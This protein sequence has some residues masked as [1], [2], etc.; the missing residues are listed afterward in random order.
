MSEL[1]CMMGKEQWM[2]E[3]VCVPNKQPNPAI[4]GKLSR[5]VMSDPIGV[6]CPFCRAWRH[7][8]APKC[9]QCGAV[10]RGM[11]R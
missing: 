10:L 5:W 6:E 1:D 3:I 7:L 8:P 9:G 4:I 11:K 2:T